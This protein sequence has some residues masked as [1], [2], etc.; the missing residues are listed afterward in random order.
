[1]SLLPTTTTTPFRPW[2]LTIQNTPPIEHG[3]DADDH[4]IQAGPLTI[5]RDPQTG[6]PD[7]TRAGAI[8]T[9]LDVSQ[10]AEPERFSATFAGQPLYQATYERDA[11]GRITRLD[12]LVAGQSHSITYD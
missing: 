3:Y 12:E 1:M 4:L 6:L 7:V 2:K 11:L 8:E 5:Q 9:D 10:F